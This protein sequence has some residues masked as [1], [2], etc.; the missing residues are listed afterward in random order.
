[1]V[2]SRQPASWRWGVAGGH[3][4][5]EKWY[6]SGLNSLPMLLWGLDYSIMGPPKPYSKQ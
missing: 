1:M 6:S 3:A 2:A 5:S 4:F